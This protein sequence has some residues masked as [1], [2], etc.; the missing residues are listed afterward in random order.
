MEKKKKESETKLK[1][2]MGSE[3][4]SQHHSKPEVVRKGGEV[5]RL[6]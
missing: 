6:T 1:L 3:G 4:G 5:N 2:Q